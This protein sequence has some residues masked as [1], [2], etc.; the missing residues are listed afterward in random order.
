M[1]NEMGMEGGENYILEY[2]STDGETY[3]QT[4]NTFYET[5]YIRNDNWTRLKGNW[6]SRFGD[7]MFYLGNKFSLVKEFINS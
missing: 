4:R 5:P 2:V 3:L 6:D 1:Y 7:F